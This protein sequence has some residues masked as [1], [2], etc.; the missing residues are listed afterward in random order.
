M[1]HENHKGIKC[2]C[3]SLESIKWSKKLFE[4]NNRIVSWNYSFDA[5]QIA[6]SLNTDANFSNEGNIRKEGRGLILITDSAVSP[7]IIQK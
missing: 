3:Y 1:L 2:M 5:K 6:E 7:F 4:A